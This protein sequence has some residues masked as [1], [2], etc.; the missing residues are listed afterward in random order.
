MLIKDKIKQLVRTNKRKVI[1][2]RRHLHQN[3]EL[4]FEEYNTSAYICA[5]LDKIG[6]E[7]TSGLVKTGII[8]LVKGKNP[9]QKTIALRADMDALPI[10]EENE[11][12]YKS[13]NDGV[14][15]ACGHDVH[16]ASLLGVAYVLHVLRDEFAGTVKLILL[17]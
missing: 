7:Y 17:K 13:I 6:V 16:S 1:E 4:S 2:Y 8:A 12:S 5:Q 14:M 9:K 15:H 10:Q 3:P 11:C